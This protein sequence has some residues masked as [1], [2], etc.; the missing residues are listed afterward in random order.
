MYQKVII[1]G[2]LGADP[3]MRYTPNGDAVT[4]FNVATNRKWTGR[5]GQPGEE[6]C[7]FRVSVW[8]KQA[9]ACNQYLAKGRQVLVEGNLTPDR[10]TGRPR[11]WT[12]SDGQPG[13]SYE[14]R[15]FTVRFLGGGG[16]DRGSSAGSATTDEGSVAED[17]IPF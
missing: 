15:A 4:S 2:N 16:R 3:E 14:L 9:E 6:T 8:G 13:T 1:I 10:E 7:W 11:I 5:D 12:S 17:E